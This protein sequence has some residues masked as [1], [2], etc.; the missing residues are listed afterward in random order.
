MILIISSFIQYKNYQKYTRLDVFKYAL[1]SYK[2]I[3]FKEIFLFIK[4]DEEYKKFKNDLDNYIYKNFKDIKVNIVHDRF[5]NQEPWINIF[6]FLLKKFGP[7]ESVWFT[8]NDDH[9]FID[10]NN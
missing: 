3:P 1:Q 6:K 2:N 9:I 4:L 8:Q 10:F 5:T 7:N